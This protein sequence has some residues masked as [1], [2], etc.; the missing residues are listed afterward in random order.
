[1]KFSRNSS[2]G[3]D[4]RRS[5]VWSMGPR[6]GFTLIEL[7]VVIAIIA[8]L[9]SLLLP[10]LSRAKM[11][12]WKAKCQSNLKQIQLAATMYKDDYAGVLLPNAPADWGLPAGS[13]SWVN[14]IYVEGWTALEGNTNLGLYTTALLAPYLGNQVGVYQCPGDIVPSANGLRVRSYSMN[15]QMGDIYLAAH[16]LDEGAL[17]Y[18]R[19]SD[20][21]NPNPS[22]AFVFCDEN[23]DSI[24][25]GYLQVDSMDGGFPDIP[26]A[27]LAGC[28]GL[29]FADGHSEMHKWQTTTL[30][31]ILVQSGKVEHSPPVSGGTANLDWI[32]FAQHSAAPV[33]KS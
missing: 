3:R 25:D 24:N 10:A 23:P 11:E 21:V 2:D 14:T 27:Y 13:E 22:M 32:W 20:I 17:Q 30:T 33:P 12:S 18:D 8:I 15:G 16:N 4:V 28:C 31:S 9:A 29:S 5:A 7:L 6:R 19:D 1:M 26:A